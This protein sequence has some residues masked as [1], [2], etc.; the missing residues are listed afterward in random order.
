MATKR[1]SL[2][3]NRHE[4]SQLSGEQKK[5]TS[6]RELLSLCL[7][8][9]SLL[10]TMLT[11]VGYGVAL[12][13]DQFGIPPESLFSSP[14]E[15]IS[16]S[17]WGVLHFFTSVGKISFLGFY[18]E[19]LS[20]LLPALACGLVGIG[21]VY[22]FAKLQPQ[23]ERIRG[24][25]PRLAKCI[26]PPKREDGPAIS[27]LKLLVYF[28]MFWLTLPAL[29]M[30]MGFVFTVVSFLLAMAPYMGMAAGKV[31]IRKD[32]LEPAACMP[33]NNREHRLNPDPRAPKTN[34]AT[35]ISL[36]T[37]RMQQDVRG[38]VVFSTSS[39]VVLFDPASGTATR[40]P[41]KDATIQAIDKLERSSAE[42]NE[43]APSGSSARGQGGS[44]SQPDEIPSKN[45]VEHTVRR[46]GRDPAA[47]TS[48]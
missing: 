14:F 21:S 43:H 37:D 16:L 26:A 46:H 3:K 20:Q 4:A 34:Y 6:K 41:L 44:A 24:R 2:R 1:N 42:R 8:V 5:S 45:T 18:R 33:L 36:K 40:M 47:R 19:M 29:Y 48:S 17:V 35:C 39:S 12:S 38:R 10:G 31:H 27:V 15:I 30:A 22:F 25:R 28:V 11:L 23:I 13:V 9:L 7:A 32:V